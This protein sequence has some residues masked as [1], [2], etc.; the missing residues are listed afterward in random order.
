MLLDDFF[1]SFLGTLTLSQQ[2]RF[3]RMDK[4]DRS[5]SLSYVETFFTGAGF[6]R[7]DG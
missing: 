3:L 5:K 1:D 7:V 4:K 6:H 2:C